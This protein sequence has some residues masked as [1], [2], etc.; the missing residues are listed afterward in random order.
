VPKII[1]FPRRQQEPPA[2]TLKVD[3]VLRRVVR[4]WRRVKL[5]LLQLRALEGRGRAA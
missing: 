1:E 5:E 2:D 3:P 4:Q